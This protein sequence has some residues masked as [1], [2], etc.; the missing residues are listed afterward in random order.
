MPSNHPNCGLSLTTGRPSLCAFGCPYPS[1]RS[2]RRS[3]HPTPNACSAPLI[4]V[5]WI[6]FFCII[7]STE[8]KM[9]IIP[10]FTGYGSVPGHSR[11]VG[12]LEYSKGHLS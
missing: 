11:F 2:R 7:H 5:R 3:S 10:E 8:R 1:T 12:V 9:V 4:A 6:S